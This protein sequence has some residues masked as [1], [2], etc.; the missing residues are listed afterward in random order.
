MKVKTKSS[1]SNLT[2]YF[3]KERAFW[4]NHSRNLHNRYICRVQTSHLTIYITA[5]CPISGTLS[6]FLHKDL[7]KFSAALNASLAI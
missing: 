2:Q 1:L 4:P 6:V 7:L 5:G 3:S